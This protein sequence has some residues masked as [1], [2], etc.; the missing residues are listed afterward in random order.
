MQKEILKMKRNVLPVFTPL[1]IL[2]LSIGL[3]NTS[4]ALNLSQVDIAKSKVSFV[5]KQMNV[6]VEGKFDKFNANVKLDTDKVEAAK[7]SIQIELGSIDTGSKE[8]NE[9]VAGKKWF[10]TKQFPIA[11]F[12]L[13][14]AKKLSEG[15]IELT[16]DLSIKGKTKP[17]TTIANLKISG[18]QATIDG[19]FIFKR[20]DY[21]IGEGIWGD[22]DVVANE[23][24]I[25]YQLLLK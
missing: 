16:G 7:G 24:Q 15:K 5:S 13:K 18:N 4:F 22:V 9:E 8:G 3:S 12:E 20:L 17:L 6:P 1:L 10:D 2:L 19:S 11:K 21:V 14:K 25:R 23:V